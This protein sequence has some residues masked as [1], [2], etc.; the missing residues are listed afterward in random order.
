MFTSHKASIWHSPDSHWLFGWQQ[1]YLHKYTLEQTKLF[2]QRNLQAVS[3]LRLM[4]IGQII[5]KLKRFR[6]MYKKR[7][8]S[9]TVLLG[10]VQ[11]TVQSDSLFA[12]TFPR[13]PD[14]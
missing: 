3:Q 9:T 13:H 1:Y 5:A 7:C 4:K 11:D 14:I 8:G 10:Y 12:Q 2:V 6:V